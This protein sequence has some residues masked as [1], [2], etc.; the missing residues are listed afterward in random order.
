MSIGSSLLL[1]HTQAQARR[2]TAAKGRGS[3]RAA[4][5]QEGTSQDCEE[6]GHISG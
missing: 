5:G 4:E 1:A 2:Q 6:G 3:V